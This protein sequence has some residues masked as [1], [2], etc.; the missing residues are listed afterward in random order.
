[1]NV[2]AHASVAKFNLM[3]AKKLY[4]FARAICEYV[5]VLTEEFERFEKRQGKRDLAMS[6]SKYDGF[7]AR[8]LVR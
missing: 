6:I 2:A 7:D 4:E 1:M 5:F 8:S 3:D